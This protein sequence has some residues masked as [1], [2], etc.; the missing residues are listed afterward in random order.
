M[1]LYSGTSTEFISDSVH[2]QI[3]DKL[4]NAFFQYYRFNPSPNEI[5]SWRN[6]LRALSQVFQYAE[7]NDHG[8]ILEYQLPLTSKRIDCLITGKDQSEKD[9]A[10]IIELKQWEKCETA[11]GENEVLTWVGGAKREVF[12][13]SIQVGRYQMYL[14]D[15]NTAFNSEN[16]V[17]LGSCSYLHNY[18]FHEDDE[19]FSQKFSQA[20]VQQPIFTADD[21][22]KFKDYLCSKLSKGKGVEVLEKIEQSQYKPSKQLMDHVS[23]IIRERSEYI[24]LDEQLIVYDKVLSLVKKGLD[25]QKK[26]VIICKRWSGNWKIGHSN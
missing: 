12:H 20:L 8:V 5:N 16:P 2:N 25:H 21:V 19:I 10:V 18:K 11:D 6:S 9:N 14:Q 24:L 13:P 17:Q 15:I 3:A 7:L 23:K 26:T 4:K 1:R 22:N